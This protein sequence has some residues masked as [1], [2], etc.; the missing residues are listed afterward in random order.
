MAWSNP[1][2]IG[3]VN[4]GNTA[5]S[6]LSKTLTASVAAGSSVILGIWG[7]DLTGATFTVSD[8]KGN[9]YSIDESDLSANASLIIYSAHNVVALTTSDHYTVSV[10][11]A[12]STV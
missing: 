9:S 8:S 2:S 12:G 11:G 3:N 10:S 1:T 4:S 6:S 7:N 5:T